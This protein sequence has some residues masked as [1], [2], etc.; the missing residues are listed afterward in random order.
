MDPVADTLAGFSAWDIPL[1][2]ENLRRLWAVEEKIEELRDRFDGKITQLHRQRIAAYRVHGVTLSFSNYR[3][4][5]AEDFG[6]AVHSIR[7]GMVRYTGKRYFRGE[8]DHLDEDDCPP[9]PEHLLGVS[10][11]EAKAFFEQEA[12]EKAGLKAQEKLREKAE[13]AARREQREREEYERL[14]QKFGGQGA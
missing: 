9:I 13:A 5:W 4:E 6:C 14:R 11:D 1:S 2:P 8:V 7:D 10:S 12:G 3:M